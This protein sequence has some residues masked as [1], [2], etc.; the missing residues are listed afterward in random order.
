MRAD[1]ALHFP[2]FSVVGCLDYQNNTVVDHPSNRER[3]SS[4]LPYSNMAT[5]RAGPQ[6]IVSFR[7][8][9]LQWLSRIEHA[10]QCCINLVGGDYG[11]RKLT[12]GLYSILGRYRTHP[13]GLSSARRFIVHC[14][15][16]GWTLQNPQPP[17]RN[18]PSV[19]FVGLRK[20]RLRLSPQA[21]ESKE[22]S[23]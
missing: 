1:E 14:A 5:L 23:S 16:H 12:A 21:R 3:T 10:L 20:R 6:I 13:Q 18:G 11:I 17:G 2:L 15:G 4:Q 9:R 22:R 8:A 19:S 7:K